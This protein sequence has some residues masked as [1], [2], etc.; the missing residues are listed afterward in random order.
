MTMDAALSK[1]IASH[2]VKLLSGLLIFLALFEWNN[3]RK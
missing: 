2:S 1:L 3:N